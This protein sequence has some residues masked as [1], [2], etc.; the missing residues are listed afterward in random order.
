MTLVGKGR[1]GKRN[2]PYCGISDGHYFIPTSSIS[3]IRYKVSMYEYPAARVC[4]ALSVTLL[5]L[6]GLY[7]FSAPVIGPVGVALSSYDHG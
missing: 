3:H 2:T 1:A 7:C 6:I 5:S 4:S